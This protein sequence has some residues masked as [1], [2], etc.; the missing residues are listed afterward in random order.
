M[1]KFAMC[2]DVIGLDR[3]GAPV[4]RDRLVRLSLV[5]KR[6]AKVDVRRRVV[7]LKAENLPVDAFRLRRPPGPMM[8]G[9]QFERVLE[10]NFPCFAHWMSG[11]GP[12][13]KLRWRDPTPRPAGTRSPC[14]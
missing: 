5:L 6:P 13:S 11:R 9:G 3:Y 14:G 10:T 8:P 4:T 1:P 7:W 2:F 12:S